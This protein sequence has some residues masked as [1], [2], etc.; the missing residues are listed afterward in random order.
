M[1]R[2]RNFPKLTFQC[3]FSTLDCIYVPNE[4]CTKSGKPLENKNIGPK[5]H[6]YLL[7]EV[8]VDGQLKMN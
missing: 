7:N 2:G 4:V 3:T 5:L 8:V 6:I 1:F